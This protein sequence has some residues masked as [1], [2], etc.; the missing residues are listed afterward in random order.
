MVSA[1][2]RRLPRRLVLASGRAL[3][4]VWAALDRRHVRIAADNLRRAFPE[5]EERRVQATARGVY[6]HFAAVLLEMLWMEGR[7]PA[8]LLALTEVEGLE[9][10]KRALARGRGVVSPIAHLGN[11]ELQ[12]V[13]TPPLIGPSAVIARPLDNPALERRL[14]SFRTSTGNAVIYKKKAL[15]RILTTLR[16]GRLVAIMLDQ[17]VQ[18]KDGIFVRFFD[19]PA[20]TTTVAAA[21]AI[22]TGCPI[23]PA[24]CVRRAD[25]RYRMVYGPEVEWKAS[26]RRD[27]DLAALTQQL[28]SVIE[29]WVRETPE[30]WLWLHRRWKTQPT[31]SPGTSLAPGPEGSAVSSDSVAPTL[32]SAETLAS[33]AVPAS[34]PRSNTPEERS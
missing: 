26:G 21:L 19:R 11:W 5:W 27:E 8:E 24:R 14:V 30:Q 16:E 1:I 15:A 2:V 33:G 3:G 22:K 17:N 25:G 4:R 32:P 28:T 6:A 12:G 13:A 10:L 7:S 29:G 23:V 31:S 34:H 18:A 9:Q 20:C